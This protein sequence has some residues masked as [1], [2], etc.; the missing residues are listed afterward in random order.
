[1]EKVAI[2][3]GGTRGIGKAI[4]L[5]LVKQDYTVYAIYSSNTK[6]ATEFGQSNPDI[7]VIQLD[8]KDDKAV[9]KTIQKI[10][11]NKGHINV[12]VNNAGIVN[13]GYFLMMSSDKWRSVLDVNLNGTFNI[14]KNVLMY[15]KLDAKGGAI[16]NI[17][18]TSG[19]AGQ[20]GQ[21][22]YSASKGAIISLTKTLAKEFA[23][24]NIR[25]NAVSPGFIET[26]MTSA[27]K[28]K[29][30]IMNTLIPLKR[31]GT[32]EEVADVVSFLLSNKASYITGKNITVDGGMIND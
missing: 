9:R 25:I 27:I 19:I 12:L 10:H 15:M 13:D 11:A 7:K 5:S 23:E 8:I 28:G 31:F 3:T 16:V 14:L 21:A 18:S 30:D 6:K 20:I 4:S 22:N 29:E 17:S 24:D 2:V 32:A 26:E 1:M